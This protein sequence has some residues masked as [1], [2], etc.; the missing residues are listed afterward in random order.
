MKRMLTRIGCI[1][2]GMAVF[3][4]APAQQ[5]TGTLFSGCGSL[6][7]ERRL[8]LPFVAPLAAGHTVIV[9][10]AAF[11]PGTMEPPAAHLAAPGHGTPTS[12]TDQSPGD[13]LR[14]APEVPAWPC[15]S[16]L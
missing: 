9:A 16:R 10:V 11:L 7:A 3:A 15:R 14:C 2:A 1:L 12:G 4:P 13:E 8:E 6:D 5:A